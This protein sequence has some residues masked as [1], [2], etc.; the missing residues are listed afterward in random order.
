VSS[1]APSSPE[2][3][4]GERGVVTSLL[5]EGERIYYVSNDGRVSVTDAVTG[6]TTL[7]CE[8]PIQGLNETVA[9]ALDADWVY[10]TFLP[11]GAPTYG[12][13]RVPKTGGTPEPIA[14]GRIDNVFVDETGLYWTK[15]DSYWPKHEVFRRRPDGTTLS[16]GMVDEVYNDLRGIFRGKA[17]L[18]V[19]S[20]AALFA[21]DIE[22]AGATMLSDVV[23]ISFPF[24]RDGA[25]FYNVDY[26]MQRGLYRAS[27]DG[28]MAQR[29]YEGT[30]QRVITDGVQWVFTVP[31]EMEADIFGASYPDG[32]RS[33]VYHSPVYTSERA[34]AL[35][36]TRLV[37][38]TAWWEFDAANI[39]ILR[40]DELG[41]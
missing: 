2:I 9:L 1:D 40:R 36:K 21:F 37:L 12:L 16:L 41:L 8:I 22:G 5:T 14:S 32:E 25:L 15:Y 24:E 30:F 11:E 4:T 38:G 31:T 10:F 7:L 20:G 29:L 28:T 6:E 34:V 35:T 19:S 13:F 23:G 39:Q 3:D 26:G 33:F 18:L 17:G 27:L